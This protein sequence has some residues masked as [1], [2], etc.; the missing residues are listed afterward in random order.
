M[1]GYYSQNEMK[2]FI[3]G[4]RDSYDN[5]QTKPL[6]V[7]SFFIGYGT[8]LFDTYLAPD[9]TGNGGGLF[10][11]T[12]S[13][14]PIIVPLVITLGGGLLRSKIKKEH[15]SDI[16]YLNNEFYIEGFQ[17]VSKVKR[18]KSTFFGSVLGVA[19]G[20]ITYYATK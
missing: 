10:K 19:T 5:Y 11:R 3:F 16:S 13:V 12:P 1:G 15:V 6:F 7:G 8:V 20:F 14:A 17:K 9:S 4:Q 2:M 18:L